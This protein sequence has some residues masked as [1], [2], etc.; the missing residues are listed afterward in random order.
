MDL[1]GT[2]FFIFAR[3]KFCGR[4]D[5]CWLRRLI[6]HSK[7]IAQMRFAAAVKRRVLAVVGVDAEAVAVC[8][9][10]EL[11]SALGLERGAGRCHKHWHDQVRHWGQRRL[12]QA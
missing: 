8:T 9:L 12:V 6:C 2:N 5:N 4:D 11:L 10:Q 7:N 1:T 3:E